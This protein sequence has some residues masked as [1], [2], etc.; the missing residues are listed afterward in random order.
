MRFVDRSRNCHD[1]EIRGFQMRRIRR[2]RHGR[3]F[4]LG[5]ADFPCPIPA[6]VEITHAIAVDVKADDRHT[7]SAERY[8]HWES[9]VTKANDCDTPHLP[10]PLPQSGACLNHDWHSAG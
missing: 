8:G 3:I 6:S 2:E 7:C 9:H 5:G 1:K 4:K 10:L